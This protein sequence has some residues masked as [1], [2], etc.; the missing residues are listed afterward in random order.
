MTAVPASAPA[1]FDW[2]APRPLAAILLG[3]LAV[4]LILLALYPYALF[5]DEAQ[6]WTW[7][8]APDF[9]YYSKP[10]MVAWLIAATTAVLGDGEFAVR[11]PSVP[12][13][14][15]T[16]WVLYLI[17]RRLYD[18]RVG[19]WCAVVWATLPAVTVSSIAVST[20]PPLILFWALAT[21]AF[22]HALDDGP[23]LRWW[24]AAGAFGGLG[25][26]S[27]YPMI[28][29]PTGLVVYLLW[30][31]EARARV[32]WPG[33][34]L[35]VGVAVLVFLPNL[36]WNLDNGFVSVRHLGE[37][38][39]VGGDLIQPVQMAEFIAGQFGVFGPILF[40]VLLLLVWR[41]RS[42]G[43]ADDRVKFLLSLCLP[44]LAVITAQALL[45]RANANWAAP[46][47][48]S[49]TVLAVGWL[50]TTGRAAWVRRS[51]ALH[52]GLAGIMTALALLSAA[53]SVSLPKGLDPFRRL[54]SWDTVALE[55]AARGKADPAAVL[56]LDHR[57]TFALVAY[58]GAPPNDMVK[59]NPDGRINDHYEL[60][61]D[62]NDHPGRPILFMSR[63][64][65]PL[66]ELG[67]YFERLVQVETIAVPQGYRTLR[68]E[69]LRADG[70]RGYA[71]ADQR[72]DRP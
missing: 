54:K 35:A 67:P 57:M 41:A 45:S 20:D 17:G 60:T 50:A 15:A 14:I 5:G 71:V 24:L 65:A 28:A 1:R 58:Y 11:L 72:G 7:A 4:R 44:I 19:A 61:T 37:N 21:W 49:A 46:A 30:S 31:A 29:W 9:G 3:I 2:T 13:H 55:I 16:A 42:M 70:F 43:R 52:V 53:E 27:K 10:P 32:H 48:V 62:L 22:L 51:V 23:R 38:A 69:V 34:A 26:L 6:Y 18:A 64:A 56:V 8:Q 25:M 47:Y 63:S 40:A 33:F 66:D 59:W 12:L 39:N 36:L 68:F